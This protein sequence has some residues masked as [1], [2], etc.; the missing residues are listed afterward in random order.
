MMH[1]IALVGLDIRVVHHFFPGV[2]VVKGR[3]S[4]HE[5]HGAALGQVRQ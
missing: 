4:L 1:G 5:D 3:V 2:A